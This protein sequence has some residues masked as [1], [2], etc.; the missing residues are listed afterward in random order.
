MMSGLL[1][2]LPGSS[3]YSSQRGVS[4]ENGSKMGRGGGGWERSP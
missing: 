1:W 4:K 2:S 3:L